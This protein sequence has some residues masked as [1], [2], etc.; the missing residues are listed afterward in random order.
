MLVLF[1]TGQEM[2]V[3]DSANSQEKETV[4]VLGF[5]QSKAQEKSGRI[6]VYGDSNC[7]D[8]SHLSKGMVFV[9]P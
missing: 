4:P 7:L 2:L 6:V 8:N 1:Y 3:K 9:R 5:L